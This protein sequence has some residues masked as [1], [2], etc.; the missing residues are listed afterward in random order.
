V[1]KKE[2]SAECKCRGNRA[3]V[4]VS[5]FLFLAAPLFSQNTPN[6]V[7]LYPEVKHM[8]SI[9]LRDMKPVSPRAG[10]SDPSDDA[11]AGLR[12]TRV[13][14]LPVTRRAS[15]QVVHSASPAQV[16]P[17]LIPQISVSSGLNIEGV[18]ADGSRLSPDTNGAV[19]ETQYVQWVNLSFEVFDKS[20]GN[21]LLGPIQGN[22]LW[23]GLGGICGNSNNGDIIAQY[24][25]IARVWVM[26]QHAYASPSSGPFY[27]CV[28]V[29]TS[30]DAMGT[31]N[32]YSLALP[33][34]FPDYP[35]LGVWPDAYYV[36]I[37]EQDATTFASL[38]ALV[39]ALDRASML[40]GLTASPAQCFQLPPNYNSLLPSDLDGSILPPTGSPSY[41][42]N[43]G[44]NSLNLWKFHVDW[45]TPTN[46]TLTGPTNIPVAGFIKACSGSGKCV[47]QVGTTQLLDGL[48]DRLM[49]RVGYR[50]FA[51]GHE[52]LVASHSVGV[53]SGIRWYEIQNPGATAEVFEQATFAPDSSYRWMP[54]IAMDQMGDIALGYSVSSSS[55]SPAIRYTGRLQSDPLNTME[56]ENSI[57][58][59]PGVELGSNRWGDYSSMSIDPVDDCTFYYTNQYQQGSGSYMW[60]TRI[61]SFKYPSCTSNPLVTLAPNGLFLGTYAVGVTSPTQ[62]VTLTN[63][64]SV[65][66]NIANVTGSGDFTQTNNTCGSSVAAQGTCTFTVSFT[67]TGLGTRTGQI[68]IN[69]DAAG[70]PQIVNLTGTGANALV[71]L[72]QSSLRLSALVGSPTSAN[73]VTLTNNGGAPLTINSIVASGDY[74]VGGNCTSVSPIAPGSGCVLNVSFTP[75]VTGTVPGEV[76]IGDNAAG[77]PHRIDLSGTGLAT[78]SVSP[79]NLAFGTIS[80]GST[81]VAQTVT[82]TNNASTTQNFSYS[83]GGNFNASSGG[84]TPCGSSPVNLSPSSKCSLSVTFSPTANGAIKGALTVQDTA[85]GVAYNPQVVSLSGSGTS[86]AGSPLSFTPTSLTFAK[87]CLLGSSV[88]PKTITVTN[89]SASSLSIVGLK[90]SGGFSLSAAQGACATGKVLA[91]GKSCSLNVKFTA[92]VHGS[93]NGSITVT[94]NAA[95]GPTTQIASL[96]GNGIWPIVFSPSSLTFSTQSVGTTSAA[97]VVTLMNY[98][99]STVNINS[100]VP[101]GDYSVASGGSAPCGST[102][103]PVSGQTPGSCSF[104]VTFTPTITGVVKG[105]ITVSHNAVGNNSPQ[106]ISLSGTGQ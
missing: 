15:A 25:K 39:C 33:S 96:S 94:D 101:S 49:Y 17:Q 57:I 77:A 28:A 51:D 91:A 53:P 79:T 36:T 34:A 38:G 68:V 78:L 63:N 45:Q 62:T 81:S 90:P 18:A 42:L 59:G 16:S 9:P 29:S 3:V 93:Q 47:P 87:P 50:H 35:K 88:G 56:G 82:I 98:S 40:A 8:K 13:S 64:Q 89:S 104:A 95:T 71:A 21:L 4:L 86:G 102:V 54:S 83:N 19:G 32:L 2:C 58:E 73:P 74:S 70:S 66:L 105:V 67:P 1:Y 60:H 24:D 31:W 103:A 75:T 84:P 97:Q 55:M 65:A 7:R 43:L 12:E 69:D 46:T 37:N 23:S 99:S 72:S 100:I 11:D 10:S 48:G 22:T 20:S 30:S 26:S 27:I 44:T 61:A 80:V 106:V 14:K 41:F 92:T 85:G 6:Q 76:S 52:S 5:S